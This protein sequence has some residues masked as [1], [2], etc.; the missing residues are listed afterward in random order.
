MEV[1]LLEEVAPVRF[2]GDLEG[3]VLR[4]NGQVRELP[5]DGILNLPLKESVIRFEQ[6]GVEPWERTVTPSRAY[7]REIR[8]TRSPRSETPPSMPTAQPVRN[9]GGKVH[10]NSLGMDMV[11]IQVPL[12]GAIGAPRGTPGRKSQEALRRIRLERSFRLAATEVS[13]AQFAR[14][15]SGHS[16]G[17]AGSVNLAASD[18]P[19]VMVRWEQAVRF[20]NWLSAQEGLP[21][22]YVEEDGRWFFDPEPGTGYRL[23][24]EAEWELVV[25]KE[26]GGAMYVWGDRMPPPQSTVHLA[27]KEAEGIVSPVLQDYRDASPGPVSVSEAFPGPEGIRGLGGNV[28]EWV[29][30]GF[31]APGQETEVQTDPVGKGRAR[32]HV[33]KGA[34]WR[35]GNWTNLRIARRDYGESPAVDLGFR[36]ARYVEPAP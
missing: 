15:D 20:C 35:D 27:G 34:G 19:V 18:L 32:F 5:A 28:R 7:Q 31:S 11:L 26:V 4:V 13:N 9:S 22:A 23:P 2:S 33:M 8:V 3:A 29:N 16:S 14:F 12:E 1:S 6:S 21:P 30:D 24:T 17:T 25:R 36:V 10:Q